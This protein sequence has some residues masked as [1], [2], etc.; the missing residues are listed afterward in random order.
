LGVRAIAGG[1]HL[2]LGTRNALV[3]L[4]PESYLEI[5]APDPDQPP[6]PRP[7]AFGVDTLKAARLVAWFVRGQNLEHLRTAA[8]AKGIP[9]DEISE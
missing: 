8:I 9:V 2:G 5:F 4:G 3:A 6:P 1:Q 7:R